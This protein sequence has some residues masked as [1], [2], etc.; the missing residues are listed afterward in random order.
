MKRLFVTGIGTE[1]G[2]TVVSAILTEK[3]K[4]DYWKPIQS[5]DLDYSDTQKVKNLTGNSTSIFHPER[6]TFSQPL[7]PHAA[8]EI[9]GVTIRLE[10]FI[11]PETKNHLIIE[12]AGGLLVPLNKEHLIADLISHLRASVV[13]VSRNYLGSI[14]H[15]LL[16]VQE[17]RRRNI[18]VLGLVFNGESTPKTE[19]IIEHYS[20]LP[21]LFKVEE[22]KVVNKAT[23]LKYAKEI[24]I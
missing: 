11:V 6:Y 18:P 7:S 2:K 23:V 9:D 15:T 19:A 14:N 13:L 3:L 10:E 21:V 16:T 20:Q 1:V 5:G 17:L 12:G 8:A 4:A 22:E 24:E